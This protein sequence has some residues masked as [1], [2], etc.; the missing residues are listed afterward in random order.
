MIY[1]F[2]KFQADIFHALQVAYAYFETI[3]M[4]STIVNTSSEVNPFDNMV[5]ATINKLKNPYKRVDLTNIYKELKRSELNNFTE[6][7]LKNRINTLLVTGK[8]IDKPNRDHPS[9]LVNG[10][11][12]P[13]TTQNDPAF[14][15]VYEPELVETP[16]TPLN[17][18]LTTLVLHRQ[19]ETPTIGQQQTSPSI[20]ENELF[21]DI[22]LKKAHYTTLK[23][24]MIM[25][26]QKRVEG[27]F[28]SELEQF[29]VKSENTL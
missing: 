6:D 12:S 5:M 3:K 11:N 27:I 20:L 17:C 25:Q 23:R 8:I 16:V 24:E 1:Y 26:L 14:D 28:N 15:N 9:Y 22:I 10:N 7:H 2:T 13:A 18:P 29:K 19:I 4:N 21:L